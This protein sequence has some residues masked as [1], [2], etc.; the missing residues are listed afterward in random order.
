MS[1]NGPFGQA[2]A[3]APLRRAPA[4]HD[5]YTSAPPGLPANAWP[6]QPANGYVDPHA[7]GYHF[8]QNA[9]PDPHFGYA[10][11][12]GQQGHQGQ[13]PPFERYPAPQVPAP[14]FQGQHAQAA[15][16]Q[17]GP[18]QDP[19]NYDLGTYT[20]VGQQGYAHG[21]EPQHFQQAQDHAAYNGQQGYADLEG[22]EYDESLADLDDEPRG[23]R[24]GLMIVAA[25]VGAI[26]LGGAMAYT[27]KV[28][29]AAGGGRAPVVKALDVGP[30]K[31]KPDM[32]GGREFANTDKKLLNRLD[33][34]GA[35]AQ[36]APAGSAQD[37][38]SSDDPNA[39]R[40]VRIIPI[41]PNGANGPNGALPT[42]G[43]GPPARSVGPS[44]VT[45]PGLTIDTS[46]LAP[47]Q[48]A[49]QRVQIP[50]QGLTPA[51]PVQQAQPQQP[52][53][54]ASAANAMTPQAADAPAAV[55]RKAIAAPARKTPVVK[56]KDASQATAAIAATSGFVAV[57]SSQKSRMDALKAFADLQQKYGDVLASK[58]PDVQEANLGDKG[59][60][61]RAVVGPPGSRDSAA[62][63]C[64]QLKTAGYPGCWVVAY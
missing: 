19:R 22:D 44:V 24:R 62:G 34:E 5:P 49:P 59:V 28:F 64:S 48:P 30:N 13:P 21:G 9:E 55:P 17:W 23:G 25:L 52:V 50:Q 16:Q 60:W 31:T 39:P 51:R 1:R 33:D 42:V 63:V 27:Y 35:Q 46:A 18:Q 53:M 26:G 56:A 3:R 15:P 32:P 6:A 41:Q 14:P 12:P 47:A 37:D 11:Q 36:A 43:Q 8:P 45:V 38:R 40:R 10:P 7:Q 29:F 2:G 58:T 57:L 20:P 4:E 54:V 61:Y